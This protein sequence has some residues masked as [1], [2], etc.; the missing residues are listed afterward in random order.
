[1]KPDRIS[2]HDS[3]PFDQQW[4]AADST[5]HGFSLK[6]SFHAIVKA[7]GQTANSAK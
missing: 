2:C 4:R 7:A 3:S 1:V 5:G 6:I